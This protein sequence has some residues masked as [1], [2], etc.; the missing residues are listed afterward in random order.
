[1]VSRAGADIRRFCRAGHS[2]RART[3][4]LGIVGPAPSDHDIPSPS[5]RHQKLR[6]DVSAAFVHLQIPPI[7]LSSYPPRPPQTSLS[8]IPDKTK[9]RDREKERREKS[10]SLS[11]KHS[12]VLTHPVVVHALSCLSD[13][14]LLLFGRARCHRYCFELKN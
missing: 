3:V 10:L 4:A 8:L 13:H 5:F 2:E 11:L 14:R 1:M 12:P 7:S 9:L 6:C